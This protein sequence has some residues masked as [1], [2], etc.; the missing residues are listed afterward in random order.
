MQNFDP[1]TQD[2]Q[3]DV[4][5]PASMPLVLFESNG[6]KLLGTMFV[7]SG[8]G[9][10]PT[11]ILMHGFPGN[12][13]NHDLAHVF[14][15]QGFNVL[16]F[17]Y[18]GCW[19]SEGDYSWKHLIEDAESAI[20]YL[21]TDSAREKYRV[22]V[23]KIILAGYS[24]GGFA[25]LYSSLSHDE[26]K[27]VVSIAGFNSGAFG[28]VLENSKEIFDYSLQAI[29]FSINFVRNT[30]AEKLL[31]EY[32]TNKKEWNLLN[33][34]DKL[35]K[36]N[37]LLIGAKYDMTAPLYIHHNPLVD[38]LK[39]HEEKLKTQNSKSETGNSKSE[40]RNPKLETHILESG[41]SFAD[42]RIELARIISNWLSRINFE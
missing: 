19:G 22:D 6:S 42:R 10:H 2:T 18:R 12:E 29:E 28:E 31:N 4:K 36:K 20:D 1:I 39:E 24:M 32:I 34:I 16:I 40:I 30:S 5:Y 8:G 9:P 17:H 33:H 14:R 15:R 13:F 26:I 27:N 21:K 25:A 37:L 3:Y 23:G 7:T 38:R 41:H 35:S 11:I